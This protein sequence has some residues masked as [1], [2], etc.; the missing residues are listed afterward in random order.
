MGISNFPTALFPTQI[1]F[2]RDVSAVTDEIT[3]AHGCHAPAPTRVD[4]ARLVSR[5]RFIHVTVHSCYVIYYFM[6][7]DLFWR[8]E[9][10]LL[11]WQVEFCTFEALY[12]V[13]YLRL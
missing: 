3:G 4:A 11:G 12:R 2:P 10:E 5:A 9:L 7:L 1:K 6:T 13:I 8:L